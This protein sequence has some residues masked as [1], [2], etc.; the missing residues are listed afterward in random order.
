MTEGREIPALS[1]D[2]VIDVALHGDRDNY[3]SAFRNA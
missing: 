3:D 1:E 2:H